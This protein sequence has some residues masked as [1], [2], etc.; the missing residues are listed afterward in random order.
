LFRL[1]RGGGML[2]VATA[3]SGCVSAPP[4]PAP[5]PE[6]P[7]VRA[8]VA[9]AAER[10]REA[11]LRLEAKNDLF[12]AS[13]QWEVVLLL[14]PDDPQARVRLAELRKSMRQIADEEISAARS[15]RHRGD[16]DHMQQSMLRVLS[17][18]PDN[19]E[20]LGA[21]R[22]LDKQRASRRAADRA[23]RARMEENAVA[24]RGRKAPGPASTEA[25]E[26]DLE[27][28]L[29]L[30]KAGDATVAVPELRRYASANPRDKASRERIATALYAQGQQRE[31]DGDGAA[32]VA[33]YSDAIKMHPAAPREWTVRL[34]QLKARLAR[35]EYEL[36]VRKMATDVPAAIAHFE[37]ALRYAPDHTQAQLR[38]ERAR[39]MQQNLRAIGTPPK[40]D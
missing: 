28:S 11:A 24:K 22:E 20:A 33:M 5:A 27:Q 29:E 15:A 13:L 31:R 7:A 9:R 4:A 8:D 18:D 12:D 19:Q 30:L 17:V 36:G 16:L 40:P 35:Q 25:G 21:L 3:L 26:Y 2:A 38:L 6:L 34:T 37:A 39:K 23:A 32:A 10:H 1:S 14:L